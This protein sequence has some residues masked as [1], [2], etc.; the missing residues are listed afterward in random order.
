MNQAQRVLLFISSVVFLLTLMFPPT[1]DTM[2]ETTGTSMKFILA[3]RH[4]FLIEGLPWIGM[5]L[6]ET[7]IVLSLY[8]ALSKEK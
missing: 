6:G 2:Y 8:F 4:E 3:G 7:L 5:F 1:R